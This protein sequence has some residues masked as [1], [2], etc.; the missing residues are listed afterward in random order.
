[1]KPDIPRLVPIWFLPVVLLVIFL[2]AQCGCKT[3][4]RTINPNSSGIKIIHPS[5]LEKQPN[6]TYKIKKANP[7]AQAKH[8]PSPM[9]K[10]K[11]VRPTITE[12][13][14]HSLEKIQSAK[15]NPVIVNPP[16]AILETAKLK[17]VKGA[18][19]KTD[20]HKIYLSVPPANTNKNNPAPK[21]KE[22]PQEESRTVID[23][24]GLWMFYFIAFLAL[25]LAWLGVGIYRDY[26][27]VKTPT[28]KS[29]AKA[30][31]TIKKTKS[32]RKASKE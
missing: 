14:S 25:V 30:K 4:G 3:G 21:P 18:V 12:I 22:E 1:M 19:V 29:K 17:P 31:K 32:R 26:K 15:A 16:K 24:I 10:S 8:V 20:G 23:W 7:M 6:G 9:V 28:K 2:L 5:S 11:P 13:S 27:K